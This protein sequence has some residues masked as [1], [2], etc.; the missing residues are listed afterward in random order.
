[1]S[2]QFAGRE[3]GEIRVQDERVTVEAHDL[4]VDHRHHEHA[5]VGEPAETARLVRYRDDGLGVPEFVDGDDA[6]IVHVGEV[7]AVV[8]PPRSFGEG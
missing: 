7:Q 1:M 5:S 4:A 2:L 6:L 8:V 3:R